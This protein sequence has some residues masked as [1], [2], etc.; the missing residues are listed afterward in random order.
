MLTN[1]AEVCRGTT[2]RRR[3]PHPFY[4]QFDR[5]RWTRDSARARLGFEGE[6]VRT[7]P[8]GTWING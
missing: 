5:G 1:M 2:P 8:T 4:A 6:V 3:V 7:R